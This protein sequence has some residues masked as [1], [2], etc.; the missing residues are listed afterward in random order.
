MQDHTGRDE[1]AAL[2]DRV[3][4]FFASWAVLLVALAAA[5]VALG[6]VAE[7][8]ALSV[9]ERDAGYTHPLALSAF[10]AYGAVWGG[11]VIGAP[12]VLLRRHIVRPDLPFLRVGYVGVAAIPFLLALVVGD[13]G[14]G[15]YVLP[16]YTQV[17]LLL[18]ALIY[19]ALARRF[20]LFDGEERRSIQK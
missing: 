17:V 4:R 2:F 16:A 18:T 20:R 19:V 3:R 1:L 10:W 6:V 5:S 14:P 12:V 9:M 15:W 8:V 13:A 7:V 11:I